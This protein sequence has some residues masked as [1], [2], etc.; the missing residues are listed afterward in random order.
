MVS[1]LFVSCKIQ[2]KD[3][4]LMAL[5]IEIGNKPETISG[6]SLVVLRWMSKDAKKF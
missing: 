5:Y 4:K 2:D 3:M 1:S 6:C